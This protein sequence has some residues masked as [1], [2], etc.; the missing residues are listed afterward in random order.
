MYA[1]NDWLGQMG[2]LEGAYN[3][4]HNTPNVISGFDIQHARP[5]YREASAAF[6]ALHVN[7]DRNA[8]YAWS[9]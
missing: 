9:Q 5:G 3:I 7:G 8:Y 2:N 4:T 1:P 6:N